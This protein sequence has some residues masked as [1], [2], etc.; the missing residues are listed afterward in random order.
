MKRLLFFLLLSNSAA[1]GQVEV[2]D[3]TCEYL[4]N[5]SVVDEPHP[6]LSWI[7]RAKN[8][9]R[10]QKQTAYQLK[11]ASSPDRLQQPDLW[12]S[13]KVSGEASNRIVY[14]GQKLPS[15]QRCY[16]QVRVWD[17]D[18]KVSAWS[19][20][21]T[22][23]M[24]LLNQ[25][26]WRAEWIGAPWQGE[27]AI[28]KPKGGPNE[29]TKILPP[30]APL[31]RKSFI[32]S[33]K[34]KSAVVYTTGLGYFEL[35][36]NGQKASDDYLVPNQT[37][38]DKRPQLTEALISLPDEFRDYQ[39]MYLAYDITD[40]LRPGTNVMGAILGNGFYNAPKFWTASYGS[41]R[42]IAQLH[43]TYA[44]GTEEVIVSDKSWKAAKSAIV[45]DLVFDG[46]IY[47][48][49][50]EQPDW[51]TSA[52]D[53]S[54]WEPAINRKAP[55]GKLVAHTAPVDK[56]TKIYQ[57]LK[58][59]KLPN[60]NYKVFFAEEI[61]GWVRLKNVSA[62]AGHT[63]KITFNANLY[64]G[65]NTYIFNGKKNASYAPRFNWF[66]FS[67]VEI[68]NWAGE[69]KT[70]NIQAEAVNTAVNESAV[71]ETSNKLF[72]QINH[73][74]KRSQ[75]DN[76]H[77]GIASDCPHRER[78]AYTGDAQV[79]CHT[80]MQNFDVKAFYKK[81]VRD[82]ASAQI[83]ATG[84]VPNGAPWQPGCGGGVAWGAA[85]Q[86][87]PWEFYRH[88]GDIAMLQENYEGMTGYLKY[89]Q[90]WVNKEGIM[91]SQ[92]TGKDNKP[93]QWWNLGEWAGVEKM[94]PDE[95]VHTFYFWLCA[96]ITSKTALILGKTQEAERY[97]AL[98][99]R[100]KNAFF[101]AFYDQQNGTF[102]KYGANI[103]ALKMGVEKDR[104]PSVINALKKDIA[105]ANGHLDTGIF[106]T[107]YFFEVL[108][109]HGL[110]ALAYEAMNKTTQPSFGHWIAL[111]STTTREQWS[112]A[113]SHNHPMFGGAL[114]WFYTR[115][116]GLQPSD[117][118][119]GYKQLLI[120]PMP[121][122]DMTYAKY[123]LETVYGKAGVEWRQ[124][125]TFE[126][127]VKVPVGSSA[128]ISIPTHKGKNITENN[129][130]LAG[131]KDIQVLEEEAGYQKVKIES[132]EYF[133]NVR[134]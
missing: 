134:P 14:G 133:F 100:T 105:E 72:N 67:A 30:P 76:M 53:D 97:K 106:G 36:V 10:G 31:L 12:D 40:K 48:S 66:V 44:D 110:H 94:P 99:D 61:S 56:I 117:A 18:H 93:L 107:R 103:F 54:K 2:G 24:G 29:R 89:M 84:Y 13:G 77:G 1:F 41:P 57:P 92:R 122:G 70:E 91:H 47:D 11:V 50:L 39:V 86:I 60:G 101:I 120:K 4:L 17:K 43:L 9:G 82:I 52:F 5:P 128:I 131:R 83:P 129:L 123:Y 27:E 95:L 78:S 118:H 108:A 63:I 7:N 42:F 115:L 113:G 34:I 65:E 21:A 49:R 46:E 119:P 64:S 55:F 116:A 130:P 79:A 124:G 38:Y 90:T 35:Y 33:K 32:A 73:I 62:P 114:G 98:A 20:V 3:L 87:I 127:I 23:K 102:G 104:Y 81:W 28:P 25:S 45:S 96:D 69:L 121:V 111:G 125:N 88:Y 15:R 26:D 8:N 6:R 68:S 85:I 132:G 59:E 37:N 16:W 75:L 109:D 112:T 58:I 80:V 74:W 22:W 71:F 126:M 19:K 51:C